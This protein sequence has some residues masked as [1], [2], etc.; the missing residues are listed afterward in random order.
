MAGI[1]EAL[2]STRERRGLSIEEVARDTR[3]SPRFLEAL[4]AEQFDELPAPVY[5]RGFIRSYASYLKLEPQPLLDQLI[6]GDSSLPGGAGGYVRGANGTNGKSKPVRRS[7]PFQRTGVVATAAAVKE[8]PAQLRRVP[9]PEPDFDS[10]AP[11]PPA[12]FNPTPIDHGY[13]AGSD[14]M[15]A[16]EYEYEEQAAYRPRTAGVLA[17]RPP[18]PGEPG[19]PRK[20]A[21]FGV[22][23]VAVLGFLMLAVFLTRSGGDGGPTN[24]AAGNLTPGL[25]PGTVIVATRSTTPTASPSVSP[26]ASAAASATV[27]STASTTP[28]SGTSTPQPTNGPG[29]PTPTATPTSGETVQPT[30]AP[31]ATA[32][33]TLKPPTPAPTV[34][35]PSHPATYSACDTSKESEKCGSASVRIL[36]FP[37]FAES[38]PSGKNDNYFVDVTGSYP[39][40]SGWRE[41][42]VYAPTSLGPVI[43]AGRSGCR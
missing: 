22:G 13:I 23:V 28:A 16:P 9:D 29:T 34:G 39:I 17:A 11:E 5:V 15:E 43:T 12:P 26:S 25:T 18:S 19:V 37:P 21:L 10:W 35:A 31:T 2:R 38:D 14:L 42:T 20:V 41:T 24:A 4:E 8:E 6:G 3:I 27:S 32:T 1:G 33:P 40:Q 30:T 36:C 7:D